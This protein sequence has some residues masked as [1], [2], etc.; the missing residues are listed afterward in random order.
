[1]NVKKY[2]IVGT[3]CLSIILI[4]S[5]GFA[6]S[7]LEFDLGVYL[8]PAGLKGDLSVKGID[9]EADASFRDV[10]SEFDMAFQLQAEAKKGKWGL[11]LDTS[12][13][14]LSEDVKLGP[15]N[16]DVTIKNWIVDVAGSYRF[17]E[18]AYSDMSGQ[19]V[20]VE[21]LAGVRYFSLDSSLDVRNTG[22]ISG[23]GRWFDPIVGGR[24]R[25]G[26]TEKLEFTL[27]GDVGGLGVGWSDSDTSVLIS[28]WSATGL[29]G[30]RI[31]PKINVWGGYRALGGK[32]ESGIEDDRFR[33]DATMS[34]PVL[35]LNFNF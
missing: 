9:T 2:R 17:Y 31:T 13:L 1:M 21:A 15:A 7:P 3:I 30:F 26:V 22:S 19:H 6:Q 10:L 32:Y 25:M 8:W 20:T 33:F 5:P 11:L 28:S 24:V 27:R 35:G 29:L 12:F 4:C 18:N 23:D 14:N 34:G 16:S